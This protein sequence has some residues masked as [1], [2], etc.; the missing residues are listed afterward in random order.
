MTS[1]LRGMGEERQV[2]GIVHPRGQK[3]Q[4]A[5]CHDDHSLWVEIAGPKGGDPWQMAPEIARD[6]AHK[7]TVAAGMAE[8]FA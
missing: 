6:L 2:V 4:V 8:G 1:S 5:A 7:L 3:R